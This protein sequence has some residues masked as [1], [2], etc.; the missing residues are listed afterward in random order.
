MS[1][2]PN[3]L[4]FSMYVLMQEE[5]FI[6]IESYSM[7]NSTISAPKFQKVEIQSSNSF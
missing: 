4:Y 1:W 6:L 3:V 2:H 7:E 5:S